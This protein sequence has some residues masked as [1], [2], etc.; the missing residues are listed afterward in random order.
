MKK[1]VRKIPKIRKTWKINPVTRVKPSEKKHNR[2][3]AVGNL[4]EIIDEVENEKSS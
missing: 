3:K 4:R 1:K 2:R